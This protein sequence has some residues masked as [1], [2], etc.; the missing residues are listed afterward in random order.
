MAVLSE[1]AKISGYRVI[2]VRDS[3]SSERRRILLPTGLFQ[4]SHRSEQLLDYNVGKEH[5]LS[6]YTR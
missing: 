5:V 6:L 3:P 4:V 2:R 1:V